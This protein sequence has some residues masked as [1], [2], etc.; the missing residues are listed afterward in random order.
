MALMTSK[1]FVM[2]KNKDLKR[3]TR[4]PHAEDGRIVYNGP[5]QVGSKIREDVDT[6]AR[7]AGRPRT[8]NRWLA[9]VK[10]TVRKAVSEKSMRVTWADETSVELY[11]TAKASDKSQ[12]TL[13]HTKFTSQSDATQAKNY[14]S[15]RLDELKKILASPQYELAPKHRKK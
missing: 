5:S 3:L 9:G 1:A 14:W 7:G 8:R 12:V 13:Q 15:E 11:F 10:W 6:G 2:P 4:S